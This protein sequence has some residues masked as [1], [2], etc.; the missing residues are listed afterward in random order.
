MTRAPQSASI[1]QYVLDQLEASKGSWPA[2]AEETGISIRTIEK[3]ARQEVENPGV[4]TVEQLA[5]HF[6]QK[7]QHNAA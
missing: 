7:P 1:H 5:R 2:V 6:Q 3:I 4:K